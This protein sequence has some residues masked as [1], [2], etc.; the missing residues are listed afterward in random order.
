MLNIK[1]LCNWCSSE[2]L[3]RGWSHLFKDCDLNF[4]CKEKVDYY[5]IFNYTH[6]YYVPEKT[7][8]FHMEPSSATKDYGFFSDPKTL[9]YSA[10]HKNCL[11][12]AELHIKTIPETEC[13]RLSKVVGILS[14][15]YGSEGHRKRI[16]FVRNFEHHGFIDIFGPSNNYNV[17]YRGNVPDEQKEN[18][19]KNYRYCFAVEN[20]FEYNYATEKI[21][22]PLVCECLVFYWGCPNLEEHLNP[23]CFVRLNLDETDIPLI[24][25][26]IEED[27]WSQR[28]DAIR[29]AKKK[30]MN[31]YIIPK[32]IKNILRNVKVVSGEKIQLFCDHFIGTDND[33]RFNPLIT[34]FTDKHVNIDTGNLSDNK[35]KI[36]CYTHLL[37]T[38]F[39]KLLALLNTCKNPF[40]LVFHNSDGNFLQEH[41][42]KLKVKNLNKI[43]SQNNTVKEV[44][45][46]PIGQANSMWPH[47]SEIK[48]NLNFPKINLIFYNFSLG[49]NRSEREKCKNEIDKLGIEWVNNTDYQSYNSLL[50]TYKFAI[51]PVGNGLDT[52]RLWECFYL[53]VVPICKFNENVN[54]LKEHVPILII[55]E[56]KDIKLINL[57]TFYDKVDWNFKY[58]DLDFHLNEIELKF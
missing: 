48:L 6:E 9:M 41:Y 44:H 16:D 8:L 20:S 28:I 57:D 32:K 10:I 14:T 26:A 4:D 54:L 50:R 45:T 12:V 30:I 46:L 3:V 31:E 19:Y 35:S 24:K 2:A 53:R 43:F 27:W 56:W 36:F 11:N 58:H 52:H 42:D 21:W 39:D 33:F 18:C 51:C 23:L 49:T 22:E 38:H 1:L 25:K 55:Y 29:A 40:N 37:Y 34:T 15:K 13:E 47:G 7:I 17:C 5:V